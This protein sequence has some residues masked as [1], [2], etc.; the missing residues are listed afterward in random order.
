MRRGDVVTVAPADDYG[1]PRPAA[2]VQTDARPEAHASVVVCQMTSDL[3]RDS[4]CSVIERNHSLQSGTYDA[5]R[6]GGVHVIKNNSFS[7]VR[8]RLS[9]SVFIVLA[10]AWPTRYL[11]A[12]IVAE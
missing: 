4:P 11:F 12:R 7:A 3:H 5:E 1:K 6:A 8:G 2:I 10:P 9:V